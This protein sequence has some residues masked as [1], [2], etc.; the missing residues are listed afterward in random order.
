MATGQSRFV[1]RVLAHESARL[2]LGRRPK[3][4]VEEFAVD[5]KGYGSG[6]L[7]PRRSCD[8]ARDACVGEANDILHGTGRRQMHADHGFHLDDARGDLD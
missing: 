1:T 7:T 8:Q 3:F 5:E 2:R 6:E 4:D